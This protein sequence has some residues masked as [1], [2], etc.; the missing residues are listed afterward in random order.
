VPPTAGLVAKFFGVGN[1]ATLFGLV[2]LTHQVGAFL[3]AWMGGRVF[4]MTGSYD[5]MWIVD[6]ALAVAAALIHMP[7]REARL[8]RSR[9]LASA[10]A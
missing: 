8:E 9:A 7:I 5:R 4:Q 3:G 2:M 6:I 10:T 1:M